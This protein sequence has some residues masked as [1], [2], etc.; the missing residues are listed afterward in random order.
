MKIKLSTGQILNFP[1]GMPKEEIKYIL[2]KKYP[3]S[4]A[5]N[6]SKVASTN[7]LRDIAA[8]L[9]G[10]GHRTLNAPYESA[11]EIQK[12][13]SP[14][15]DLFKEKLNLE[16]YLAPKK[17]ESSPG[18]LENLA[19]KF[20]QKN[21]VPESMINKDWNKLFDV[22]N[23]P[24]QQEYDFSKML[25]QQGEGTLV[26]KAIQKGITYA[27]ELV[28]LG[29]LLRKLPITAGPGKRVLNQVKKEIE[30]RGVEKL[31][32]PEHIFEDIEQNKFLR[33]TQP[34]RNLL[35][36]AKQGGYNEL[37][38]LQSDLGGIERG[39][40]RDPFSA[41]N[42]QFGKDVGKNRQELLESM[43]NEL[44]NLGH[45]DLAE[46]MKHG[47][48]LY[49]QYMKVRPYRNAALALGVTGIPGY[50]YAKK[51]IP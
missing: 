20:N 34:N 10:L 14:M 48:K 12:L 15:A 18:Y 3:I 31:N 36:R 8:G 24:H 43:R 51:L 22:K 33:N 23:I 44:S 19:N 45:E 25:G 17:E 16:K 38:D 46:L 2:N 1:D 29:A 9:A 35:E 32:T 37:F 13:S 49:R 39:Y 4:S 28:S 26:D 47:Q 41:A 40:T 11:K 50:K 30:K 6:E 5:I 42:R 21:K 7:P 27:P